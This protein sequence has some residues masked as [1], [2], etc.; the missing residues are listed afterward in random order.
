LINR[1]HLEYGFRYYSPGQGRFLNRDP[2]NEPG[3]QLVREVKKEGDVDE[4]ANLYAFVDNDPVNNW[5]YLGLLDSGDCWRMY[6]QCQVEVGKGV[7]KCIGWTGASVTTSIAV[8]LATC[9]KSGPL[10]AH[11][12]AACGLGQTC[13]T[14]WASWRCGKAG[15]KALDGCEAS[16]NRCMQSVGPPGWPVASR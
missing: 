7:V 14:I 4:E 16:F 3:S 10:T 6:R 8:C 13:L 5:D 9:A 12:L 15:K 2:I 11:C 1:R